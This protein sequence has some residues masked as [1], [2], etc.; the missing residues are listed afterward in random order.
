MG[1]SP[2][3]GEGGGEVRGGD[4]SLPG[5]GP[6][7][8]FVSE[9]ISRRCPRPRGVLRED[10]VHS[11]GPSSAW[12]SL[13]AAH[14]SLPSHRARSRAPVSSL[15]ACSVFP[16]SALPLPPTSFCPDAP[17]PPRLP[18]LGTGIQVRPP[19][20]LCRPTGV[21]K[22][23]RPSVRPPGAGADHAQRLPLPTS[24]VPVVHPGGTRSACPR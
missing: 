2:G 19:P 23:G 22:S 12:T 8:P 11:P 13:G 5:I 20:S 7:V 6:R 18:S 16:A 24:R 10:C 1:A 17:L 15:L 21:Y 9:A 4:C 14:P 3:A